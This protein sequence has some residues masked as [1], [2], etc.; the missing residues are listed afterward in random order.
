MKEQL[1]EAPGLQ[2]QNRAPGNRV[3]VYPVRVALMAVRIS[4]RASVGREV[5]RAAP[6]VLPDFVPPQL[7][8]LTT[9]APD[10]SDWAHELKWDGYRIHARI[11]SEDVR[12]LTRTG[13]DWTYRYAAIVEAL[14]AL[15][16][17]HA[18]LDGE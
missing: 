7:T 4:R 13:L 1:E 9:E 8:A 12:L 2:E 11:E 17:E 18:Y 6:N 14:R 5:R 3:V 16:V 15:P 10:G